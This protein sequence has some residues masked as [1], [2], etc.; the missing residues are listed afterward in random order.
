MPAVA[1]KS[2]ATWILVVSFLSAALAFLVAAY[3]YFSPAD[4]L[5]NVNLKARGFSY[6]TQM[7]AARQATLGVLFL[8]AAG[9]KSVS[10]LTAAW[11]FFGVMNLLDAAIG[12]ERHDRGLTEGAV[13][14]CVI[15]GVML[16]FLYKAGR[17]RPTERM[18]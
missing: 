12:V 9:R 15:A 7:W 5:E 11:L 1:P 13:V 10:L 18:G 16:Y 14:M 3:L 17:A 6:L 4:V 2:V 8:Y